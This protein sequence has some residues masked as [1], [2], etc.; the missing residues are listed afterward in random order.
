[1]SENRLAFNA[2]Q[3]NYVI[4][5]LKNRASP[6]F[7]LK[8]GSQDLP[9]ASETIILGVFIDNRLSFKLHIDNTCNS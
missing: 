8:I 6:G 7:D 3:P 2:D 9:K 1:M 5:D 4:I